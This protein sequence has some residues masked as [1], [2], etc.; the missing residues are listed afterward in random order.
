M[1]QVARKDDNGMAMVVVVGSMTVLMVLVLGALAYT[2]HSQKFARYDQDYNAAM[3]AAQAGVD[4]YV[5]RLNRMDTYHVSVDCSNEALKGPMTAANS[6]GWNLTTE[7]GWLPV[8]PGG[9]ASDDA[10]FHYSVDASNVRSQGTIIL[11]STGRSRDVYRTIEVAVGKGGSTDYVYYTDFESGDPAN[12]L[13]YPSTPSVA[14]GR[15]GTSGA[16]YYWQSPTRSGCV[17]IQFASADVLDGRVFSNDAIMSNGATF[18]QGIES[19]NPD[20]RTVTSSTSTWRNCLRA[21]SSPRTATF[22]KQPVY[23]NPLYLDDNSTA[24]MGYPGCHYYGAT[25]VIFNANGTMTVWSKDSNFSGAVIAVPDENGTI[26]TCGTGSA[27]AST[28][29]ATVPVPSD[30]VIYVAAAPTSG[31][32]AVVRRELYAGEIGGPTG[33][34]LPLG[35]YSAADATAPTTH[36]RSYVS[37]VN[38]ASA[39]RYKGEG[40]LYVQGVLKGRVTVAAAQSVIVTGDIVLADGLNGTDMLGLVATNSVE[41][42]HP[43]LVTYCS[44]RSSDNATSQACRTSGSGYTYKWSSARSEGESGSSPYGSYGEWPQRINDPSA[45]R[46]VPTNGVQIAGSI[47]TLLHSFFVQEYN[48][49]PRQGELLVRGSIAQRW[50]GAVGTSA[51][52]GYDKNYTYD[53]RLKYSAPPYFP[54][55]VNAEWS[56][57]YSGELTT[58]ATVKSG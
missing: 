21:V 36:S 35:T 11:T 37:D 54:N 10:A 58:P 28:A 45:G 23:A 18:Q 38:M 2:M 16:Q 24:F 44:I 1:R 34:T 52:T 53:E 42:M 22:G 40:N 12:K 30:M 14:C 49:G 3:T 31:S 19:A 26:P 46:K 9:S 33:S 27:L 8:T 6:C 56:L 32:G 57:R 41:V 15:N 4:D 50:R 17:E 29:G 39:T 7:P 43:R 13:F 47:Q 48:K 5:S 25:R 51:G 55:W 20:C